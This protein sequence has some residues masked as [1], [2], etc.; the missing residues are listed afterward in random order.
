MHALALTQLALDDNKVTPGILGFI[1]FI[2]L[3]LA[4][5][6]LFKNMN[7]QFHKVDFEE[8]PDPKATVPAPSSPPAS[9]SG[10]AASSAPAAEEK[11][12]KK[13]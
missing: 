11:R 5:W 6:W 4:C 9:S 3:A 8:A 13:A 10:P 1:V 7:R 2:V 12:Q